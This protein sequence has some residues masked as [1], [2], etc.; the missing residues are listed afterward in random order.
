MF[1]YHA[2]LVSTST[3]L[4]WTGITAGEAG[5]KLAE[6]IFELG[7]LM[8]TVSLFVILLC[9]LIPKS[10]FAQALNPEVIWAM[11]A[12]ARI[13]CVT[14]V[15]GRM[16]VEYGTTPALGNTSP[17]EWRDWPDRDVTRHYVNLLNLQPSTTYYYRVRITP[18]GGGADVV[19][20]IK[21][22]KTFRRFSKLFPSVLY[23]SYIIG[24]DWSAGDTNAPYH[25]WNAQHYDIDIAYAF[26]NAPLVKAVNP[27]AVLLRYDNIT[28]SYAVAWREQ[29]MHWMQWADQQ[30]I[31]YE[32]IALH[33]AVDT[34]VDINAV[35]DR[36]FEN[37]ML[38]LLVSGRWKP[39]RFD[40]YSYKFPNIV[41]EFVVIGRSL[42]FDIIYL[43][44]KTPASGGYDG[45]WEYCNQVDANGKPTGWAPLTIIEDTTVVGGQRFAQNGYVRFVPPKERAEWKRCRQYYVGSD[46]DEFYHPQQWRRVFYVRFR[47]TQTGT[48]PTFNNM[49]GIQDEDFVKVGPSGKQVIPGWDS[50]WETNPENNGDPE[51][52][53]NPPTS[54]GLGVAK[55]ARFKWWSRA[56]YYRPD[57]L[58]FL[59]NVFDPY[60][61]Q[62]LSGPWLEYI[63]DTNP[64]IEGWYCDNYTANTSPGTPLSPSTTH[65]VEVGTYDKYEYTKG[66]GEVMEKASVKLTQ[67]DMVSC[68]NDLI[69]IATGDTW[70]NSFLTDR[71]DLLWIYFAP[72]IANREITM[73]YGQ[74][75]TGGNIS[76]LN[77]FFAEMAYRVY[78]RGQ[79]HVPMYAYTTATKAETN[80]QEWWDREKMRALAQY[81]LVRDPQKE[82]LFLNAWHQNFFY[83]E[84]LTDPNNS[85][86]RY[87]VGG[88][89]KQKAYYIDAA[90]LD[91]GQPITTVEPPYSQWVAY[92]SSWFPG[93]IPG[94]FVIHYTDKAP[95]PPHLPVARLCL[96]ESCF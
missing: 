52:N 91:L 61:I 13:K 80:T 83:G 41:N 47:V 42:R 35:G 79:Y 62:W 25:T 92:P 93:V 69:N 57:L 63:R 82:F 59:T 51:Y 81:L 86:N 17:P 73:L 88:I 29:N 28:N 72:A 7:C 4:F 36:K 77:T 38:M 15:P 90:T 50:S 39:E 6:R 10:V 89:P 16:T 43:T 84:F 70:S 60:Y 53:P 87:Y 18:E 85:L 11:P 75:Y 64:G 65:F 21:T 32:H 71:P 67:W 94:L 23:S 26:Q 56:W 54:G 44:I 22:F 2:M 33:Y 8:R 78:A 34:E 96:A 74:V 45:V 49:D 37:I 27:D 24:S 40:Y 3:P 5:N 55:S 9:L 14:A 20:D 58:R 95:P 12:S 30:N 1:L 31:S 46:A 19:S 66:M 68:A 76:S 48:A